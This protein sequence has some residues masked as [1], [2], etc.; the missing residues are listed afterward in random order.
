MCS[1][2]S[3]IGVLLTSHA[4]LQWLNYEFPNCILKKSSTKKNIFFIE[5]VKYLF[6]AQLVNMV[7]SNQNYY[8][9]NIITPW[10]ITQAWSILQLFKVKTVNFYMW[11]IIYMNLLNLLSFFQYF[12]NLLSFNLISP[13]TAVRA[14]WGS[15]ILF[16]T[17]RV[18]VNLGPIIQAQN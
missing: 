6:H 5:L 16:C 1:I 11:W 9:Y 4:N 7:W 17:E 8:N 14:K 15:D 2:F 18:V 13:T 3:R 12:L 10:K